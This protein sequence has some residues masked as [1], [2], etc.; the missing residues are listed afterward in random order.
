MTGWSASLVG[1]LPLNDDFSV[2]GQLGLL[3]WDASAR[4]PTLNDSGTDL[5]VGA[6]LNWHV[7]KQWAISAG[8]EVADVDIKST[9]LGL[10]FRF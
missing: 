1:T 5:L 7:S 6:G 4:S 10:Q 2:Y 9:K 8:Y 3:S